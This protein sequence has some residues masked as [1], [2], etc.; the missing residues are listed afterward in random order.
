M[1]AGATQAGTVHVGC[2]CS[3]LLEGDE[4]HS[5]ENIAKMRSGRPLEDHDR[6]GWLSELN[7]KLSDVVR[8]G[9]RAVLT[10]SALK[11]KYRAV[12]LNLIHQ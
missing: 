7:A 2:Q 1:E 12:H 6:L 10:C 4:Y 5:P 3:W 11:D 9:G 8:S